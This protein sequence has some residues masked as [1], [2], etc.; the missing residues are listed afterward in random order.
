LRSHRGRRRP[1]LRHDQ[2]LQFVRFVHPLLLS[3]LERVREPLTI[4]F[5]PSVTALVTCKSAHRLGHFDKGLMT[6]LDAATYE[7]ASSRVGDR[8]R[9]HVEKQGAIRAKLV[10]VSHHSQTMERVQASTS[11]SCRVVVGVERDPHLRELR[12]VMRSGS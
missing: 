10:A 4:L 5:E 11:V 7:S 8:L 3:S 12:Q 6:F 1:S 9:E 2:R